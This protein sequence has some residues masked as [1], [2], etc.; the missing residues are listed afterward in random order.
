MWLKPVLLVPEFSKFEKSNVNFSRE[1]RNS[2]KYREFRK[3]AHSKNR[4]FEKLGVKLQC[5]TEANPRET[6]CGSKNRE[7]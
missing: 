3:I 6:T 5:V 7:F 2:S 1:E 4:A